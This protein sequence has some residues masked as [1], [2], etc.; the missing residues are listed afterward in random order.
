[1]AA[2]FADCNLNPKKDEFRGSIAAKYDNRASFAFGNPSAGL[3]QQAVEDRNRRETLLGGPEAAA[4]LAQKLLKMQ[5]TKGGQS[6]ADWS[7]LKGVLEGSEKAE[8]ASTYKHPEKA[9]TKNKHSSLSN[10]DAKSLSSSSS[11]ES[12]DGQIQRLRAEIA[13]VKAKRQEEKRQRQEKKAEKEAA[14]KEAASEKKA[15]SRRSSVRRPSIRR[16]SVALCFSLPTIES[17]RRTSRKGILTRSVS[18]RNSHSQRRG[19]ARSS[20]IKFADEEQSSST[21]RTRWF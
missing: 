20:S 15:S 21:E 10:N 16:P 1:M 14:E 19:S 4:E 2:F 18:R 13:R 9:S 7:K 5:Q 12:E 11:S 17:S 6:G 8:T 3:V